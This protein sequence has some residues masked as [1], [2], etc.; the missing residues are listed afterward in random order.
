MPIAI[1]H[2]KFIV[3]ADARTGDDL[4]L[5]FDPS[6]PDLHR[7]LLAAARKKYEKMGILV[8]CHGG[9]RLTVKDDM[10][11]FYSKSLDFGHFKNEVVERL[12]PEH[13]QFTGKSYRFFVKAGADTPAEVLADGTRF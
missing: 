8:R 4:A 6:L 7:E 10:V 2:T 12:A 1:H 5:Y 9:G 11:V 13:P 3:L